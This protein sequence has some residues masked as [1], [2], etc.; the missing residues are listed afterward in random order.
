MQLQGAGDK[1]EMAEHLWG[2]A[3]LRAGCRVPF[4]AEPDVVAQSEEAFEQLG[5]FGLLSGEVQGVDEPERAGQE[6][7]FPA[8]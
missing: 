3:E 6:Q 2:V 1:R 7:S 8:G 5:G 4:F